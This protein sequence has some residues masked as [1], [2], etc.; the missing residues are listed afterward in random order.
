[1][2]SSSNLDKSKYVKHADV[3]LDKVV[4]RKK[5]PGIERENADQYYPY[6]PTH[7]QWTKIEHA[8]SIIHIVYISKNRSIVSLY[9]LIRFVQISILC[10]ELLNEF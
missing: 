10:L 6:R 9:N 8:L 5:H 7:F 4:S 3:L 2:P 1:M